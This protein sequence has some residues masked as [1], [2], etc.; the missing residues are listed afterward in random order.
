MIAVIKKILVSAT[1]VVFFLG[2][3]GCQM[4]SYQTGGMPSLPGGSTTI[5]PPSSSQPSGSQSPS[6][7]TQAPSGGQPGM[8]DS[9][10]MPGSEGGES[11][12]DLDGALD[13]SLD[14]F[15]DTLAEK[16]GDARIDEI[17]ILSPAGG[18][19][20]ED[21]DEIGPLSD[22][23][24]IV[25]ENQDYDMEAQSGAKLETSDGEMTQAAI[26]ETPRQGSETSRSASVPEDIGDGQG[27][28]IVLRQIREA[29]MKERNPV[30]REK[31]WDEYRKIKGI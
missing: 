25:V 24:D 27:D 6:T 4:P 1:I 20:L 15:D 5:S 3:V 18:S 30:L 2:V 10:K 19:S 29:A 12:E 16:S 11:M 21:D 17:D 8:P 14:G 22:A 23:G 28:D 7:G 9:S 26:E 31:L 13:D